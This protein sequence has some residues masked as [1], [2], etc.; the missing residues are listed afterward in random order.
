MLFRSQKGVKVAWDQGLVREDFLLLTGSS[1][2]DLKVGA[3]QLPGR[4]GDGVDLLH[5]PMSFRDFCTQVEGIHLPEDPCCISDF[6]R[7]RGR[8]LARELYLSTRTLSRSFQ[9]YLRIGGFPA[10]VRDYVASDDGSARPQSVRMLWDA[11]AGDIARSGRDQT[12]AAKLLEEVAVS[13]GSPLKWQGA[14]RSMGMASGATAR[15]YVEHLSESFALLAVYFWDLAGGSLQPSKQRKVY[16]LDPLFAEI[17]PLLMPGA[18]RPPGDA[19]VE[20]AVASGLFRSSASALTQSGAEPGAVGY[21]RSAAGREI[22]FVVPAEERGRGGRLPLEVKGDN[23]SAISR[24]RMAI[25]NAFG[26]G[27]V[28]SRTE[29]DPRGPVPVIPVPVLLAALGERPERGPGT[30]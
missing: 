22:D 5:L 12:A 10:A 3:E 1:A 8:R 4:R 6:L 29:F 27:V 13:L 30:L 11:L 14:A 20:N 25:R 24:A 7:A 26:E 2:R 21:W 9:T 17:A 16:F 19:A 28:A 23:A 18:R 15:E